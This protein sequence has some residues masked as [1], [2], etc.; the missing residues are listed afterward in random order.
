MTVPRPM[1][2]VAKQE[3]FETRLS[4]WFITSL[5]GIPLDRKRPL[6][7]RASIKSLWDLLGRG[8]GIVIFP[9]GTYY[10][11]KMGPGHSGLVRMICGRMQVPCVPAGIRYGPGRFARPVRI[12]FG[13]AIYWG[14]GGTEPYERIMR[15]IANLSGL[16]FTKENSGVRYFEKGV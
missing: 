13:E 15:E 8:E 2:Y 16:E 12:V 10:P 6:R 11:D 9:E 4:R 5:G 14:A 3:L 7:S 1:F